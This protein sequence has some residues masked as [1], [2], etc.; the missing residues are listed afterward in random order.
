VC[1]GSGTEACACTRWSADGE[2]CATCRGTSRSPCHAC[3]GGGHR[4]PLLAR[5]PVQG[6][7][8]PWLSRGWGV[9][10][11]SAP[12][13][14]FPSRRT[15]ARRAG[16]AVSRRLAVARGQPTAREPAIRHLPRW[17]RLTDKPACQRRPAA[18][19]AA[20]SCAAHAGRLLPAAAV[21]PRRIGRCCTPGLLEKCKQSV[22]LPCRATPLPRWPQPGQACE[23]VGAPHA[24]TRGAGLPHVRR[25]TRVCVH[26]C[27]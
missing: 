1:Q 17:P 11:E 23:P 9:S 12:P 13:L 3:R 25:R 22:C 10:R 24:A 2:G 21:P 8:P 14:A 4:R 20:V 7:R 27:L 16:L 5:L 26:L 6:A 18:Q 19:P 15:R